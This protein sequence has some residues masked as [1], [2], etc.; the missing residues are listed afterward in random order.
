MK[1]TI[2]TI[3]ALTLL[4]SCSKSDKEDTPAD[5]KVTTKSDTSGSDTAA[6]TDTSKEPGD[7]APAKL[8]S[9][10]NAKNLY[11]YPPAGEGPHTGF[12][13]AA[14]RDKL[15]GTWMVGGTAFSSIPKIW[16]V[17][18]DAVT[19][20]DGKGK[21]SEHTLEL[22]SPCYA[23]LGDEG[24]SSATYINFVF[25]GDTFYQGLGSSGLVASDTT[26]G[27]VSSGVYV[28]KGDTCT[29]WRKKSF[30]RKG[31]AVF[32]TEP[33]ECGFEGEGDK[34]LFFADDTNSKRKLYGKQTLPVRIGD[35]L[36]TKQM[37]S[38][39]AEK[40]ASLEVAIA[41]QKEL[42]D[43]K[44]ALTRPPEELAYAAWE[45]P[46]TELTPDSKDRFWAAGID[47][48]GEWRLAGYRYKS[49]H[50]DTIWLRG[51]SDRFAPSAFVV[52]A[53]KQT[54]DF[55]KG[56]PIASI[57]GIM[58]YGVVE[59]VDAEKVT[60]SYL[61]GSKLST[62]SGKPDMFISIGNGKFTLGSPLRW[63]DGDRW[64]I[65]WAVYDAGDKVYVLQAQDSTL[66]PM[67]K[68]KLKLIT[69]N[70]PLK[71]GTKV[72][73]REK[74]GMGGL[75][76][77]PAKILKVHGKGAAYDVKTDAGKLFTQSW[78]YVTKK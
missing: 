67:D 11:T 33:G 59:S 77:V 50:D 7:K 45:L 76:W 46:K 44:D 13:L 22:Y 6:G 20:I 65:G 43:A 31:E 10:V 35:A 12:D 28:L 4:A 62:K 72:L 5:T 60:M 41:K 38:N 2:R 52:P 14:V 69:G 30:P 48:D 8:D 42:L 71:K 9:K 27:C 74:S 64:P 26:I 36:M 21:R 70:K 66:V 78:A 58:L 47:R 24:G 75:K 51:M 63:Q 16:H 19:V 34:K 1:P 55:K 57:A 18:G 29:M 15:Q 56:Q 17:T 53:S 54:S 37:S 32:E 3:L 23:K 61:S 39:K 49:T 68:A 40:V 73:A 25:D